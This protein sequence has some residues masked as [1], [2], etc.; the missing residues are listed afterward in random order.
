MAHGEQPASGGRKAP[1]P[2]ARRRFVPSAKTRVDLVRRL[3]VPL[4]LASVPFFWVAD[5][6][7]RASLTTLGRDQGIFQYIA[8]AV[9]LGDVDYRDI[10]DVNGPLIHLIHSA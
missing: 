3:L 9:R 8:W 1:P 7:H 2:P 4:I 10:R 5:A 6:T